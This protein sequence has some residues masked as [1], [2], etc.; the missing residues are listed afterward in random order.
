MYNIRAYQISEKINVTSI[1]TKDAANRIYSD[2]KELFFQ[3]GKES[4]VSVF[5]Y[6]VV[7]FFNCNEKVI[8]D[9]FGLVSGYCDGFFYDDEITKEYQ[10]ETHIEETKFGF[11]RTDIVFVDSENIRIF[12]QN[13]ASS[14]ALDNY[15]QHTRLLLAKTNEHV[16]F[17]EK[18]GII[19]IS[20]EKLKRFIGETH[21]LKNKIVANLRFLDS[22]SEVNQDDYLIAV[23]S[24]I[25]EALF[26]ERRANNIYEEL[27]IVNEHLECFREIVINGANMKIAW[28]EII[29]LATFA[30][31]IIVENCF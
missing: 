10:I 30:I 8:S 2:R 23:D 20:N 1:P 29:L 24:G 5:N 15:S 14:V 3:Y 25:K 31:K 13:I 11:K 19:S 28:I 18:E 9:F 7:S 16:S 4:Y 27:N 21:N 12:M 17:L 26:I 6:G 22:D